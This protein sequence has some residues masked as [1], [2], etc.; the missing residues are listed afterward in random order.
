MSD[1]PIIEIDEVTHGKLT[2]MVQNM[3]ILQGQINLI[4]DTYL[5]AKE[6]DPKIAYDFSDD[7]SKLVLVPAPASSKLGSVN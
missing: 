3:G 1:V 6:I 7:L 2:K 4:R 5:A